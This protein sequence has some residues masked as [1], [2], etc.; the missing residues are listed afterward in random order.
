M[1]THW[2]QIPAL[3]LLSYVISVAQALSVSLS[4]EDSLEYPITS[5]MSDNQS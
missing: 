3:L 2:V 4:P 1:Q 5:F